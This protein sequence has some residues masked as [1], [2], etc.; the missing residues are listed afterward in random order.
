MERVGQIELGDIAKDSI[1]GF[2][3]VVVVEIKH[4]HGCRRL[5]LQPEECGKDGKP[6][7]AQVFDEPQ[8]TLVKAKNHQAKRANGGP[9][10][11]HVLLARPDV[12][13]RQRL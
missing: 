8:V 5:G 12:L 11:D 3:G 6:I 1:S 2:K 10:P 9:R 7:E 4:I 13:A